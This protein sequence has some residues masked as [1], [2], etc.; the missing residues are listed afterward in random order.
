MLGKENKR[1]LSGE[2]KEVSETGKSN[3]MVVRTEVIWSQVVQ[4]E[5]YLGRSLESAVIKC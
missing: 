3:V 2:D 5:N 1:T 4:G